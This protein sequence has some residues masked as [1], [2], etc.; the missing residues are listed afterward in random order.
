MHLRQYY[1]FFHTHKHLNSLVLQLI[2]SV[3]HHARAQ[4]TARALAVPVCLEASAHVVIT[5]NAVTLVVVVK[6]PVVA[7][8]HHNNIHDLTIEF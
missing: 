6:V 3:V 7:L 8:K 1:G 2:A 4:M 5:A